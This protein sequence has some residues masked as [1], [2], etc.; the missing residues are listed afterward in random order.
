MQKLISDVLLPLHRIKSF[1]ELWDQLIDSEVIS[2]DV[3][4]TLL[5]RDVADKNDIFRLVQKKWNATHNEKLVDFKQQRQ[6]AFQT[7]YQKRGAKTQL[8]DI[9]QELDVPMAVADVE[10]DI[11]HCLNRANQ[12]LLEIFKGLQ[13]LGKRIVILADTYLDKADVAMLLAENGYVGYEKLYLS[14]EY[15]VDKATGV[16]FEH[17]LQEL[18]IQANQ[19]IHVGDTKATDYIGA[20]RVDIECILIPKEIKNIEF[21]KNA[22]LQLNIVQTFINNQMLRYEYD[23]YQKFGYSIFG[24]MLLGFSQWLEPRVAKQQVYFLARDGFVLKE[25]FNRLYPK[26]KT[27][28]MHVS[29][30]SLQVPL[31]A[32]ASTLTEVLEIVN[33]PIR[34]T[35]KQFI[36]ACG[37]NDVATLPISKQYLFVRDD[38]N[39]EL[40]AL[41]QFYQD[42]I[43][44]QA[45]YEV[46]GLNRYLN[47]LNFSHDS[48]LVDIGWHGN[49]QRALEAFCQQNNIDVSL[50]GYYFGIATSTHET[51]KSFGFWFDQIA[52]PKQV[53]LARPVQGIL[54][55]LFSANEGST[56][57]Y[58][59][60]DGK[61]SPQLKQYEYTGTHELVIQGQLLRTIRE[62]A[63]QLVE[64]FAKSDLTDLITLNA[65]DATINFKKATFKPTRL[66]ME[67][68]EDFVFVDRN[69]KYLVSPHSN[70]YYLWHPYQFKNDFLISRW[71]IGMLKRIFKLPINYLGMYNQLMKY[72]GIR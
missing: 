19:I 71:P 44:Q 21:T 49:K 53:D 51:I 37:I 52:N 6:A 34:F 54:E 22:S 28:Y 17:I 45:Q 70:M 20:R 60:S 57:S 48:A 61:V 63:L 12:P 1:E 10:L 4:N 23:G 14:S 72:F 24:P 33:L 66:F 68:Y 35:A 67:Q 27:Q 69:V 46:N 11:E 40:Q 65:N 41:Y 58:I 7:A 59:I 42:T 18:D 62:A 9:Y 31:L 16:L 32:N 50:V 30:R 5:K 15:G 36:N 47:S 64:D 39:I 3:F 56:M 8:K 55:F 13:Q 38:Q 26:I 43:K 25:A 2:F 29:R